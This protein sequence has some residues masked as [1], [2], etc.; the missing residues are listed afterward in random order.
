MMDHLTPLI[1]M[2]VKMMVDQ[3][4]MMALM[5]SFLKTHQ[6]FQK[7]SWTNETSR[8]H[9]TSSLYFHELSSQMLNIFDKG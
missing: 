6:E 7:W 1:A 3:K 8:T 5:I 2:K 4:M 9:G